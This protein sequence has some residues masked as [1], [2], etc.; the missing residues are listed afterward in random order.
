MRPVF[1]CFGGLAYLWPSHV[2]AQ[3]ATVDGPNLGFAN[4]QGVLFGTRASEEMQSLVGVALPILWIMMLICAFVLLLLLWVMVRYNRRANPKPSETTHSTILEVLWT[5]IP[6]IIVITIGFFGVRQVLEFERTPVLGMVLA[7]GSYDPDQTVLDINVYGMPSW[8]WEYEL[9]YFGD[10]Q[11]LVEHPEF[12]DTELGE[13]VLKSGF[14]YSS[15]MLEHP[16]KERRQ[17]VPAGDI[18]A[19]VAQWTQPGRDL[20]FYQFDVDH[21]LVVPSGVR[22]NVNVQGPL[23]ADKQHAWAVPAFGVKRDFWPGRVNPAH[24]FVPEG[25][26]GL[27]FGQ[28]SEFCGAY[29]AYMPIA[30]HVVT[31][32]E[33]RAYFAAQMATA[34]EAAAEGGLFAPDYLPVNL[35]APYGTADS[36]ASR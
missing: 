34:L 7:D 14:R 5:G 25:N 1:V 9:T 28:C 29:H 33:Y 18:E 36:L 27:Y 31:L 6:T 10:V 16:E 24:F 3:L 23:D 20:D 17:A 26:E 30:V 11:T 13:G 22:I 8:N 12:Y 2:L 32:E 15:N 19:T 4:P 21:R 35:P